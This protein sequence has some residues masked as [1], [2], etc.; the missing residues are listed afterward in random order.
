VL[1]FIL[2]KGG[3]DG[4]QSSALRQLVEASVTEGTVS[5][6]LTESAFKAGLR[7][8][9]FDTFVVGRLEG[10]ASTTAPL[11]SD[12]TGLELGAAV[13]R[14]KGLYFVQDFASQW[15]FMDFP[16]GIWFHSDQPPGSVHLNA[17]AFSSEGNLGTPGG[18]KLG[19]NSASTVGTWPTGTTAV[20]S[21]AFGLGASVV[22]G[23]DPVV[24]TPP[25]PAQALVRDGISFVAPDQ[26]AALPRGTIPVTVRVKNLGPAAQLRIDETL[27]PAVAVVAVLDGGTASGASTLSWATSLE[28]DAEARLRYVARFPA[29]AGAYPAATRV[30][31]VGTGGESLQGT[32]SV[33]L[34]LEDGAS[35]LMARAR[36]LTEQLPTAGD[37]GT[38]RANILASLDWLMA[39]EAG[40]VTA[41]EKEWG[42][43]QLVYAA[44]EARSLTGVDLILLSFS[45][46]NLLG[47]WEAR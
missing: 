44:W 36:T 11:M 20:S 4:T 46:S 40:G 8:D 25:A 5:S 1:T 12:L 31:V 18:V 28:H 29:A 13:F 14:G 22:V 32:A 16:L 47:Y 21:N 39:Y 41:E 27:D 42:I 17:S 23:F 3:T 7:S 15:W 43:Q 10:N 9:A 26:V 33:D 45:I 24:A 2:E 6:A 34:V 38:H 19:I 30:Y 35:E 37:N